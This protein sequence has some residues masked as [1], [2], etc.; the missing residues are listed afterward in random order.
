[1]FTPSFFSSSPLPLYPISWLGLALAATAEG[2]RRTTIFL[3]PFLLLFL[4]GSSLCPDSEW[5]V[6][7]CREGIS[8]DGAN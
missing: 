4:E 5:E 2:E 8:T 6:E 3:L 1:M 7:N